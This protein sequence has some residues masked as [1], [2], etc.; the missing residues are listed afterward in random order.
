MNSHEQDP[1]SRILEST[2]HLLVTG[3]P[4]SGKTTIALRK[5]LRKID[6]G[7]LPGQSILFLSFSRAAVARILQA[8]EKE[9]P[10]PVM[11]Q[12][13]IQTFHSFCWEFLKCHGYLLGSPRKLEVLLPHD[14][15]ALSGG[16]GRTDKR[17]PAWEVERKKL[18][19]QEGR[20]AF[21][22]FAPM[23]VNLFERSSL[24][25]KLIANQFPMVIVD[26]AQDTG[27]DAWR[28]IEL[29]AA[30]VPVVCLADLE[31]QIFDFL[32]G[33]GPARIA[34]IKSDLKPLC[35]DL[36]TEN[37]R[38]PGTEIVAFA[39]DILACRVTTKSYKGIICRTYDP[40]TC[41]YKQQLVISLN[42]LRAAVIEKTGHRPRNYAI[43]ATTGASINRI[44]NAL[45]S[46]EKPIPHKVFF[47]EAEVLLASRIVAFLLEP[48]QHDELNG[49]VAKCLEFIAD[50]KRASGQHATQIAN[51]IHWAELLRSGK[52]PKA[53]LVSE[54]VKVIL[55]V[56]DVRFVGV[57]EK[58]WLTV[59][60]MLRSSLSRDIAVIA[61]H[62][63]YL[64]AFNRGK[65][66]S[67]NLSALWSEWG[68]YR[69]AREAIDEA[70]TQDWLLSGIDDLSGI[71]VLTIHR[72]KGKE[73]DAVIIF[74]DRSWPDKN[75]CWHSDLIWRDDP[76]PFLR[77][78]KILR[79][80]ITRA[81]H[82]VLIVKPAYPKCPILP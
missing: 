72:A 13:S 28:C 42:M 46:G 11:K 16:I 2:G 14:E 12:L 71:H 45:N 62:L 54:L 40:K 31:Q 69:G 75:A 50:M 34:C 30:T 43:L 15:K 22:L 41:N 27:P 8:S 1:R 48:K 36:G 65:R 56:R 24:L 80:A 53:N 18:F 66:I 58:D 60:R 47:D 64:V 20:V 6:E 7:L 51:F 21:D 23:V 67:S 74:S 19:L 55:F 3:G 79:V 35:V 25:R 82:C 44:S 57:P 17:W 77:S 52:R 61:E 59:K 26:E 9:I 10:T 76:V 68:S 38:S 73:F 78:R 70:L 5:A 81:V 39:N 37:N 63:D 29:L 33:I 4:G 49:D 32:P